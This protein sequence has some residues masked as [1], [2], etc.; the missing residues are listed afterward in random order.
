MIP[1]PTP[2]NMHK[3]GEDRTSSSEDMIADIQTHIHRSTHTH[4][5]RHA[6]HNTPLR[7]RAGRNKKTVPRCRVDRRRRGSSWSVW[8]PRA[9]CTRER[10]RDEFG[11][12][13]TTTSPGVGARARPPRSRT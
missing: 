1:R 2:G 13:P 10:T 12:C 8:Q 3:I 4:T 9:A 7:Y 6:H 11:S 5:D